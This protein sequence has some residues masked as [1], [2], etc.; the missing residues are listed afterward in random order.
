M[1]D[2]KITGG[3]VYVDGEFIE[4]NIYVKGEK[5]TN[6]TPKNL[7]STTIFDCQG[8]SVIPGIID[9]HTHMA[10]DV[11]K[12]IS[13]DDFVTGS[14]AALYGGVTTIVD[15]LDPVSTIEELVQ[16]FKKRT[17]QAKD[18]LI[19]VKF[20]AC[21]ANPK[22][23]LDQLTDKI[24]EL[25]MNTIKIFTTYSDSNRRTYDPQILEL[26][27]LSKKKNFLLVVHAENDDM[28]ISNKK[29]PYTKLPDLRPTVSE[30]TEALKLAQMVKETNGNLYMV[31]LSSGITLEALKQRYGELLNKHFFVESCPHYFL[32]DREML[33]RE[34][35]YLY[36]MAPPLRSI[37]E[38]RLI[39]SL[40]EDVYTIGTD[41]C[42]FSLEEKNRKW[43]HDIPLG[44]G[45]IE[46]SFRIMHTL[47]GNQV[48]PKMTENVAKRHGIY[49]QKG[50]IQVGSDA[51][52]FIY[53]FE[54]SKVGCGHG[55][56][57]YSVYERLPVNG[58]V[59]ATMSRGE[60]VLKEDT[61]IPH[62]GKLLL[63][64]G[65]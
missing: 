20:H 8:A 36:T 31:H 51:D 14:I 11:G 40:F 38:K 45:G 44:I 33:Q 53:K 60:F 43:L 50:T 3:K 34:D 65:Q 16:T 55:A 7:P 29:A 41:H 37:R 2:I 17:R 24:L 12:F 22:D 52:L 39:R 63:A 23:D 54:H 18:A 64:G 59:I 9:P 5:I 30:T 62:K 27:K 58:R 56:N 21:L 61:I 25:G 48:I 42:P 15:F 4:T 6:I 32:F 47:F 1:Y 13:S 19:D 26:L 57:Q 35:G 46:E 49:P 28:I 10:L